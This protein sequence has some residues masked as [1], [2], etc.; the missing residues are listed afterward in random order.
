MLRPI[1]LVSLMLLPIGCDKSSPPDA[2]TATPA[3]A[4]PSAAEPTTEEP[5]AASLPDRDAAL[6]HR[7]VDEGAVLLDV[8]TEKEFDERH[9]E[10]ATNI[11]HKELPD[12]LSEIDAATGGD[13][14]KPI[15]LYCGSGHRAGIAKE[16]LVEAGYTQVTNLGGIDDW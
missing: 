9:L 7:L 5:A 3:A 15:V 8:R 11:S 2:K 12:R 13:K 14:S 1:A 10:G 6:A 16:A 4:E